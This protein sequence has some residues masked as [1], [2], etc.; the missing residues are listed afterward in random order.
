[1]RD[2]KQ[3]EHIAIDL[4]CHNLLKAGLLVARPEFDTRA[5]DLLVLMTVEEDAK[6]CRVQAKYRS[7]S[8][9]RSCTLCIAT[10]Y[11]SPSLVVFLYIES[12]DSRADNLFTFFHNDLAKW[13][14]N[15]KHEYSLTVNRSHFKEALSR[16]RYDDQKSY[17]I[18]ELLKRSNAASESRYL[19]LSSAVPV[20]PVIFAEPTP[21][22]QIFRMPTGLQ[23]VPLVTNP[24]TGV[25]MLGSPCP[26][27]PAR[28]TYNPSTDT[29]SASSVLRHPPPNIPP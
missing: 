27:D 6:F 12:G 15:A 20:A 13:K 10:R 11:V 4:I 19:H 24:S 1:M 14:V 22:V 2:T 18:K 23:F 29:W 9:Q 16:F 8:T 7:L 3:L 21:D 5:A 25:Q 17:R 28:F 26:G